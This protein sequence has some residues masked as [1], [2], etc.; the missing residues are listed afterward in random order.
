MSQEMGS[1]SRVAEIVNQVVAEETK[2]N[3]FVTSTGIRFKLK[4]VSNLLILDA[5]KKIPVPAVPVVF[6]ED[7]GREEENPSD[8]LYIQ[9]MTDYNSERGLLTSTLI[10]AYGTEVISMPEGYIPFECDDWADD[11]KE[12]GI[13]VPIKGRA[14]YAT[15]IKYHLIQ[16]DQDMGDLLKAVMR[17][18]GNT[19]E[20]DVKQAEGSFRG[21]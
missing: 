17:F 14:R 20:E 3:E 8:P 9:R 5:T 6:L 4:K 21:N 16:N 10:L 12:F 18:S 11:L 13:S 2:F 19:I 15:W 7:K 1:S